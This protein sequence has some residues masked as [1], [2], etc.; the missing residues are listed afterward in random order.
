[1]S[2]KNNKVEYESIQQDNEFGLSSPIEDDSIAADRADYNGPTLFDAQLET[3]DI[4]FLNCDYK[5]LLHDMQS[6][7]ILVDLILTDPPYC[8]S[9]DYQLGFS[10]MGRSGM[11]YGNWDYNF[12]Q[13]EWINLCAPYVK[14]GG[15]AIIFNDWKNLSYLVE[16]LLDNGFVIKDLIRWEKTNPMP[17]NVNSRYVMDFEV[18]IWAVKGN[19]G[20]TFNKPK[21]VPYLKPV[22]RTGVV[23]GGSKRIHPTQKHLEL[24]EGI[25][26]VHTN[27]GDLVFDPFTGSGTTAVACKNT[28]RNFVGSEID[29]GYFDKAEK[30]I[31]DCL[32]T[33]LSRK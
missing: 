17:R 25:L 31:N 19:K 11:N 21:N 3:D 4:T 26:K 30:R 16:A 1:M 28:G 9:R 27:P 10:N 18:A 22:Y 6:K 8:V 20:W 33:K 32:T 13:K 23:L 29:K 7:G 5:A 14:P 2:E 24:F 15:S 12:D